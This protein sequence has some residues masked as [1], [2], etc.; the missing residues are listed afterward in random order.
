MFA[1]VAILSIM[2]IFNFGGNGFTLATIRMTPRLWTKSNLILASMLL[3]NVISGILIVFW[4][5]PFILVVYVFD[6]PCRFNVAVAALTPLMKMTPLVNHAHLILISMERYIAIVYPLHYESKFTDRTLKWAIFTA[7]A[8]GIF[9]G[10]TYMMWLINADLRRCVIIPIQY[11]MVEV[12]AY[13][14]V[15]ATMFVC[16]GKIL[17]VSRRL[18]RRGEPEP[19]TINVATRATSLTSSSAHNSKAASGN[20]T[21][22]PTDKALPSVEVPPAPARAASVELTQEQQ[23]QKI[24]SRRRE[25]KAVYLTTARR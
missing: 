11:Q 10:M 22:N 3:T 8:T 23:R 1:R 5:N 20:N 9:A 19:V 16:Y 14:L 12:Y 2:Q 18:R 25:L 21:V 4:Y 7:W 24:K 13:M 6:N 15:C 17:A